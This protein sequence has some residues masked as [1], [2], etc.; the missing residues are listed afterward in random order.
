MNKALFFTVIFLV[1]IV[2]GNLSGQQS[3]VKN[4]NVPGTEPLS[5][6][7]VPQDSVSGNVNSTNSSPAEPEDVK[8][9]NDKPGNSEG[10]SAADQKT[11]NTESGRKNITEETKNTDQTQVTTV[12]PVQERYIIGNGLLEID[13]GNFKYKRIPG[14]SLP[15]E[16]SAESFFD[17]EVGS[18]DINESGVDNSFGI[19][20]STAVLFLL[21]MLIVI[22]IV[23]K[24]RS[25]TS[26]GKK[27]LRRFP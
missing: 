10:Q 6:N 19:K 11:E 18:L 20:K 15:S 3:T 1:S 14:I 27:V 5:G 8:P 17:D 23:F 9:N 25:K 12:K 4:E 7:S 2:T 24:I 13:E 26:G 16:K 22:I 21:I